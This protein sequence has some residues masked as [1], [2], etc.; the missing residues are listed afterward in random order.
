MAA[1][2]VPK[3][4]VLS[5]RTQSVYKRNKRSLDPMFKLRSNVGT[6]IANSLSNHGYIKTSTTADILGCSIAEFK[7][8]LE[9]QFVQGMSWAN[10]SEWHID[11]IVPQAFAR[12]EQELLLLNHYT[13]LRPIWKLDNLSKGA[14]IVELAQEHPLYK[15]ITE[16]RIPL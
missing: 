15:L 12:T 13:N 3:Q 8:Y 2:R 9:S 7:I 11:H 16:H 1:K 14:A 10:R 5:N 6:L 4:R